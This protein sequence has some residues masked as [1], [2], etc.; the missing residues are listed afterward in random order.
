MF[1]KDD[2]KCKSCKGHDLCKALD[3]L[4]KAADEYEPEVPTDKEIRDNVIDYLLHIGPFLDEKFAM[5]LY[6]ELKPKDILNVINVSTDIVL[7]LM[8]SWEMKCNELD[9]LKVQLE[10]QEAINHG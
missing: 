7:G 10:A 1:C 4:K 6:Y 5:E 3:E 9:K 2:E 8:L